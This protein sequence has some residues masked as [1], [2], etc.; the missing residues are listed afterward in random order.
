MCVEAGKPLILTD[1]EII[2]G[3]LIVNAEKKWQRR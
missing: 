3:M 1:L 2:Y